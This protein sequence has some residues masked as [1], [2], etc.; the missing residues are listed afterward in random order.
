MAYRSDTGGRGSA[1][2]AT[3]AASLVWQ[4]VFQLIAGW[5]LNRA[6]IP[7]PK[8]AHG[9]MQAVL[10]SSPHSLVANFHYWGGLFF[11][12]H[13]LAHL[14]LMLFAGMFRP[15]NQWRWFTAIMFVVCAM[16]FQITGNLLP[17]DRHGVQSAAIEGGIMASVP[18]GQSVAALLMGGQPAFNEN[19]L[20]TWYFAHRILIPVALAIGVLASLG[21]LFRS[22]GAKAH[23]I[24][25]AIFALVPA[26]I[27]F[28][29]SRP[30]GTMATAADYN[31]FGATVG[32]YSWP[33]HGS[34]NAFNQIDPALGWIGSTVVPLVFGVFLLAAPALSS[35]LANAGVQFLFVVFVAY[36]VTVGIL[37]GG[38]PAPLTG[39][40]DPEVEAYQAPSPSGGDPV[41]EALAARGRT[42]FNSAPCV[43]CHGTDGE[44]SK[45]GP[46]LAMVG[47]RQSD[48]QW[49]IDFIRDPQS[50]KPG[51][52]MPGF[53]DLDQETV[54]VIA[55]FLRSKR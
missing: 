12:A 37:F 30:L 16:L 51:T 9:T 55:E 8:L 23:A 27:A 6:Y 26:A 47:A 20:P 35:K 11:L 34:L 33:L 2:A 46:N 24:V 40:R 42:A 10:E 25:A 39:S 38:K 49:F 1:I 7:S 44:Q 32:W 17:F 19:T 48:A 36:F 21:A 50:K 18:G 4:F 28:G 3:S 14:T 15:P 43:G 41:D 31:L 29:I 53:R 13:S 45:G 5:Y 22:Q 52:T 54:R